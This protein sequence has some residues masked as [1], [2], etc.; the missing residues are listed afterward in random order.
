MRDDGIGD[1]GEQT[2][3]NKQQRMTDD[4]AQVSR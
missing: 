3:N 2:T 1:D 4:G